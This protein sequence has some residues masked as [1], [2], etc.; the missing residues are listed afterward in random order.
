MSRSSAPL[1]P[2]TGE[3]RRGRENAV[4]SRAGCAGFRHWPPGCGHH[5]VP[6]LKH[7]GTPF[8]DLAQ[9]S[10]LPSDVHARQAI[11]VNPSLEQMPDPKFLLGL[12]NVCG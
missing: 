10:K 6:Y 11:A 2:A 12:L 3:K 4:C 7:T 8:Q 1:L 5:P 9:S